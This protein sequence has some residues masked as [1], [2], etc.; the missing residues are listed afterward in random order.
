MLSDFDKLL[1]HFDKTVDLTLNIFLRL[2]VGYI[3][4][5]RKRPLGGLVRRISFKH[6]IDIIGQAQIEVQRCWKKGVFR[7]LGVLACR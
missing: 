1:R 2:P 5:T 6:A 3:A 7:F 4:E